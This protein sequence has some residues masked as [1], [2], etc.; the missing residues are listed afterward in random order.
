MRLTSWHKL[1]KFEG[2][3]LTLLTKT[4]SAEVVLL[5]NN[6]P[7]NKTSSRHKAA[8]SQLPGI[9]ITTVSQL[10]RKSARSCSLGCGHDLLSKVQFKG[11][12][13][14]ANLIIRFSSTC[15]PSNDAMN[16]NY[17]M[18]LLLTKNYPNELEHVASWNL[19]A[20][21]SSLFYI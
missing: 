9:F 14:L 12:K 7:A 13:N 16:V 17:Q 19:S 21:S 3:P 10:Y 20:P 8:S 2:S 4:E 18:M 15:H 1:R 6:F 11:V 5:R